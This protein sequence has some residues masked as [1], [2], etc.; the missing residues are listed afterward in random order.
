[1]IIKGKIH[2]K[3]ITIININ[4]PN[5]RVPKYM[6]QKLTQFKGEVYNSTITAD[7]FNNLLSQINRTARQKINQKVGELNNIINQLDLAEIYRT[8]Y[9]TA[10]DTLFSNGHRIFSRIDFILGHKIGLNKLKMF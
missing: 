1:M 7:D 6:K 8:L 4:Q 3:D 2:K 5:R 10:E 9:S